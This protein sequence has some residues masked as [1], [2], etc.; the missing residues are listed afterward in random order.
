MNSILFNLNQNTNLFFV[1]HAETEYNSKHIVAGRA[2]TQLTEKGICQAKKAGVFLNSNNISLALHSPIQ[3]AQ[4]TTELITEQITPSPT[5]LALKNLVEIDTGIWT[6]KCRLDIQETT[7]EH[8]NHFRK[9]SWEGVDQAE[10]IASLL[11]RCKSVWTNLV[12]YAN[13]GHPNILVVSHGGFMQW[14]F[15]TSFAADG[16]HTHAWAPIVKISNCDIQQLVVEPVIKQDGSRDGAYAFWNI[17]PHI[18][19]N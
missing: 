18:C 7:P 17:S 3:R 14:L 2:E 15:K 4:H 6:H 19:Y 16:P 8:Y 12:E 1:R 13:Q 5:L 9:H 11:A 10:K